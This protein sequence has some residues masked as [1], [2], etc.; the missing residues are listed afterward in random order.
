MLKGIGVSG[1]IVWGKAVILSR[2]AMQV[3]EYHIPAEQVEPEISRFQEAVKRSHSQLV[4]ISK[5]LGRD[6]GQEHSYV[7]DTHI[8]ILE[9]PTFVNA[10]TETISR[11]RM[12][13]EWALRRAMDHF[14]KIF[15]EVADEYIKE[16]RRDVE[17][18]GR[19]LLHNLMG[20]SPDV[21]ASFQEPV[22]VIAHD[23][24]PADTLHFTRGKVLGFVTDI[25]SATSHTAIMARAL[26][27]PAVVGLKNISERV[28]TGDLLLIDGEEGI[29][30][31]NPSQD[32]LEFYRG[33]QVR[34]KTE[35]AVLEKLKDL[36]A[37][38]TDGKEIVL[39]ANIEYSGEVETALEHGARGIGLYRTEY[40]FVQRRTLP[41]EE[42]QFR[43][44]RKIAESVKPHFAVI[45]TLDL[46]GDKF[47]SP[48]QIGGGSNPAL[49]L[50]AIRFCL[51]ERGLFKTQLRAVL[52]ASHFGNLRLMY[53]LICSVDEVRQAREILDE[54]RR[55]LQAEGIPFDP[56]LKVGI[57]IET[58]AAVV[59]ADLLAE[60]A[61]FFSIGTNDLSQYSL[62]IDRV[63]EEVAYL[64]DP[65]HPCILRSIHS[66]V[67]AAHSRGIWVDICGEMSGDPMNAMVLLGLELDGLSM[68]P[69]SIPRIKDALR[70]LSFSDAREVALNALHLATGAEVRGYLTAE[71]RRRFGLKLV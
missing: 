3:P 8:L 29:V 51:Q 15:S 71:A 12:N 64:Y 21:L 31:L 39:A 32:V 2:P 6:L 68:N 36:P 37:R 60:E 9:D 46:G 43:E 26:E 30:V 52:R 4:S 59:I 13:A 61:A 53:P 38:T 50:R 44:Y 5:H 10:A 42:E 56:D 20:H 63:N 1:G 11:Y 18:V 35:V 14:V 41:S 23:L 57:M 55:E 48:L 24:T 22:I 17:Q 25:G 66:V 62:A 69:L 54:A 33:K 7:L 16:R 65:L 49:G 58:P 67:A 40:L 27:I 70:A 19:R 47:L 34:L 28:E 45:R